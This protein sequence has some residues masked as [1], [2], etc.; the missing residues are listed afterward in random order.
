MALTNIQIYLYIIPLFLVASVVYTRYTQ[1]NIS[2]AEF[3]MCL[4]VSLLWPAMFIIVALLVSF[5]IITM[6]KLIMTEIS[7]SWDK[8]KNKAI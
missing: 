4:L 6:P 3:C 8:I 2:V 7:T 1:G 5:F